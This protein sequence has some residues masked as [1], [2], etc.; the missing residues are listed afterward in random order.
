VRLDIHHTGLRTNGGAVEIIGDVSVHAEPVEAFLGFFSRINLDSIDSRRARTEYDNAVEGKMAV[1][2]IADYF[3]LRLGS[4]VLCELRGQRCGRETG[5]DRYCSSLS[6]T[7]RSVH[8][9]L[10]QLRG[11]L[12]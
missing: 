1:E 5:K 12:I 9:S 4:Y 2:T 7:E 8:A 6:A 3:R 10:C 11:R